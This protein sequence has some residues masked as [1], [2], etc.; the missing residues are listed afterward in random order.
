VHLGHPDVAAINAMVEEMRAEATAV[1]EQGSFGAPL[2][3]ECF[4]LMRY[5]G[6]GHEL[7]VSFPTRT[8]TESDIT[9][10]AK[11]FDRQYEKNYSRSVPSVGTEALTWTMT[12]R[13]ASAGTVRM[14]PDPA[15]TDAEIAQAHGEREIFDA[16]TGQFLTAK[17]YR[18]EALRA[19]QKVE[20]PAAIVEDQTTTIL[21][22]RFTAYVNVFGYLDI[23]RKPE[24]AAK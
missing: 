21:T 22:K 13:T 12:V 15:T 1:V 23:R 4:A 19:G 14:A 8:L 18:R 11:N 3:A 20:G 2:E 17:V 7:S 16:D 24:G 9:E 10:L 6:Q 5:I